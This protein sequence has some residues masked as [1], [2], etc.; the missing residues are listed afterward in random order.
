MVQVQ[1][2]KAFL[3]NDAQNAMEQENWDANK[4]INSKFIQL[5]SHFIVRLHSL[6][7]NTQFSYDPANE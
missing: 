4:S 1:R 7:L 5:V 6:K 2:V 3:E